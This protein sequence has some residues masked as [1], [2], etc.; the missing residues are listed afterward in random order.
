MIQKWAPREGWILLSGLHHLLESQEKTGTNL[1]READLRP[2]R[3]RAGEEIT[4]IE[5]LKAEGS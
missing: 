3:I 2:Q 1:E 4:G 5:D